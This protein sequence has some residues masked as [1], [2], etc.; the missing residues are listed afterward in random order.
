M[1]LA[2]DIFGFWPRA[3]Y[4]NIW[5]NLSHLPMLNKLGS[6][7]RS[8]AYPSTPIDVWYR[9]AFSRRLQCSNQDAPTSE[10]LCEP[11]M[12]SDV[13]SGQFCPST[14]NVSFRQSL[15]R[16]S[17]FNLD[18]HRIDIHSLWN[19]PPMLTY[20][21]RLDIVTSCGDVM[22]LADGIGAPIPKFSFSKPVNI[23]IPMHSSTRKDRGSFDKSKWRILVFKIILTNRI[24]T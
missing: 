19:F 5:P 17:D 8:W 16:V 13:R 10:T 12:S 3:M 23:E 4:S 6:P 15:F 7:R 18:K 11:L 1:L 14:V 20:W 22:W 21:A 2:S 24:V 9:F